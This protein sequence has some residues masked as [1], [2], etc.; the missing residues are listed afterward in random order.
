[1][2]PKERAMARAHRPDIQDAAA[3]ELVTDALSLLKRDH[4]VVERLFSEFDEAVGQQVDP[5][6]R[7]ICK[8]LNLH[9]QIEEEIFY[10]ASRAVADPKLVDA[11][12][13]EHAAVKERIVRIEA[14]TSEHPEFDAAMEELARETSIHV[15]E[16]EEELFP[17][18]VGT[19]LDLEALGVA[20]AERK[21]TLMEVMGLHED[22]ELR[23]TPDPAGSSVAG[24]VPR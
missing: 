23:A 10:P 22:D 13:A 6:A 16:E 9:A 14:M 24:H 8:M 3:E 11:A 5:V 18:L 19:K 15:K 4:R 17:Q 1:M 7:R 12:L 21:E 2:S 20:L